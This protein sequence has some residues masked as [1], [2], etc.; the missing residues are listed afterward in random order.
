MKIPKH[1]PTVAVI[2]GSGLYDL[3]EHLTEVEELTVHT[4]YGETSDTI[5]SG[6]LRQEGVTV[7][8]LFL[9][10]H[11]V[12]HRIL[13]S[14]VNYRANIWALKKLGAQWCIAVSA[15]GSLKE[16]IEPGNV[17][18]V[19]QYIDKTYK[20]ECTF[21]GNGVAGHVPFG[22]PVSP[23]LTHVLFEAADNLEVSVQRGGTYMVMEGPAFS[24]KAESGV[25][26]LF[27]ADVIGMTA[28]PEAKLAREAGIPYATLAMVTD[29]DCWYAGHGEVS[30]DEVARVMQ[31]LSST[32]LRIVVEAACN[33]PSKQDSFIVEACNGAVMTD[34]RYVSN[35][36]MQKLFWVFSQ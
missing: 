1:I 33:I 15:V 9:P 24:T 2:G 27:G 35:E 17:V 13:P 36:L 19:D 28:L 16:E 7:S 3:Q 23:K 20:R 30:A 11:G 26:R 18:I 10:R 4:P 6:L 25:H 21:F 29:Y 22:T 8:I 31:Q 12:G 14:E 34:P 32:A 5:V